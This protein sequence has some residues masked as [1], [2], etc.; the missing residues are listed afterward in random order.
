[1]SNTNARK[2]ARLPYT[3]KPQ[4]QPTALHPAREKELCKAGRRRPSPIPTTGET[5]SSSG[6]CPSPSST[7]ERQE[8]YD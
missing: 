8:S 5:R 7:Y 4:P 3:P 2:R 6:S 1:M